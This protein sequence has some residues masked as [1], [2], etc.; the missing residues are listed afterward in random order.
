M[1]RLLKIIDNNSNCL[2]LFCFHF[3]HHH[4]YQ[5]PADVSPYF[6]LNPARW[7]V[8]LPAT[9]HSQL[10]QLGPDDSY[11]PTSATADQRLDTTNDVIGGKGRISGCTTREVTKSGRRSRRHKSAATKNWHQSTE[12]PDHHAISRNNCQNGS[13]TNYN[14][15]STDRK[16]SDSG[17]PEHRRRTVDLLSLTDSNTWEQ[18]KLTAVD[19]LAV[20]TVV[21]A[22]RLPVSDRRPDSSDDDEDNDVHPPVWIRRIP[23]NVPRT[24]RRSET[25]RVAGM[26]SLEGGS[27][28]DRTATHGDRKSTKMIESGRDCFHQRSRTTR[29]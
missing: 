2:A 16:Y 5:F 7:P 19:R 8:G 4:S 18:T 1:H 25:P 12:T 27:V 29:S 13:S 14:H 20:D 28:D 17:L 6:N 11:S 10:L 23:D 22:Q 26:W 15:S 24:T 3:F 21:P 9:V